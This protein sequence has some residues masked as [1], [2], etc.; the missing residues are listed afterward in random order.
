MTNQPVRSLEFAG[1]L[2]WSVTLL[3]SGALLI[4]SGS[5]VRVSDGPPIK[6][7][8]LSRVRRWRCAALG[9]K[10]C[11]MPP[12]EEIGSPRGA[13]DRRKGDGKTALPVE[14]RLGR[15]YPD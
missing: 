14:A 8:G 12:Q 9:S 2:G 10:R 4:I 1:S 7:K 5:G 11:P 15:L 13:S 6:I 3:W